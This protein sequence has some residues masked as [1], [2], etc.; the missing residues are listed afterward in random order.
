MDWAVAE[1]ELS[2]ETERTRRLARH[3]G[4]D[5]WPAL[6][7]PPSALELPHAITSCMHGIRATTPIYLSLT[8]AAPA[9]VDIDPIL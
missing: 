9:P 3:R 1:I 6:T 5:N 2:S 7:P 8:R 4:E